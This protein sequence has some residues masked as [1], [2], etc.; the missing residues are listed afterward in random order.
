MLY[1]PPT[2]F[3]APT[4]DNTKIQIF[5]NMAKYFFIIVFL[6]TIKFY[7]F[8][9]FFDLKTYHFNKKPEQKFCSGFSYNCIDGY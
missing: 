4:N 2:P 8:D 5:H 6:F 1:R 7:F 3:R 9:I